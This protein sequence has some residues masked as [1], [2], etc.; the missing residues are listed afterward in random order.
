MSDGVCSSSVRQEA[1]ALRS[2]KETRPATQLFAPTC[3]VCRPMDTDLGSHSFD[4]DIFVRTSGLVVEP[5]VMCMIA[6]LHCNCPRSFDIDT[7]S[8]GSAKV[9]PSLHFLQN[10]LLFVRI[11]GWPQSNCRHGVYHQTSV[12]A[13]PQTISSL[14]LP[15]ACVTEALLKHSWSWRQWW[16]R[17]FKLSLVSHSFHCYNH[18]LNAP[19][20]LTH[21]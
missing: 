17:R 13:G 3:A 15:A 1:Q 20:L 21:D 9:I 8:S 4:A 19:R 16:L 6:C 7:G 5:R 12:C 10:V 18:S 14:S 11:I 2:R